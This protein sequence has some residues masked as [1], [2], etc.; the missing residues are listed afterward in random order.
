MLIEYIC[1]AMQFPK[2][3]DLS[4]IIAFDFKP[5]KVTCNV[6]HEIGMQD[7]LTEQVPS[8]KLRQENTIYNILGTFCM[9]IEV[10]RYFSFVKICLL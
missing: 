6:Q 9:F 5:K 3:D 10:Y 2:R 8:T 1:Y 7:T 4:L